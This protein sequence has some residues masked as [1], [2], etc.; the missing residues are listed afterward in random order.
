[1][2][3][4]AGLTLAL[5]ADVGVVNA[6]PQGF[7]FGIPFE[8]PQLPSI[9]CTTPSAQSQAI[10]TT[11]SWSAVDAPCT[12]TV[13]VRST[14]TIKPLPVTK[15]KM[16]TRYGS[17]TTTRPPNVGAAPPVVSS[18]TT[19]VR[20]VTNKSL[21]TST[22]GTV[23]SFTTTTVVIKA[24]ST[25]IVPVPPGFR[26][27]KR[28]IIDGVTLS[29]KDETDGDDEDDGTGIQPA[30]QTGI[31]TALTP[32]NLI[33]VTTSSTTVDGPETVSDTEMTSIAL[34]VNYTFPTPRILATVTAVSDTETDTGIDFET[35]T[36]TDM[37]LTGLTYTLPTP[38]LISI[39]GGDS[40]ETGIETVLPTTTFDT[41]YTSQITATPVLG[42]G[43]G[44]EDPVTES[45]TDTTTMEL[46]GVFTFPSPQILDTPTTATVKCNV[47]FFKNPCKKVTKKAMRTKTLRAKTST[48]TTTI[49]VPKVTKRALVTVTSTSTEVYTVYTST[50]TSYAACN[51]DNLISKV[52]NQYIQRF[53]DRTNSFTTP[54]A[55]AT[56]CCIQAVTRNNINLF[57]YYNG[58]CELYPNDG[59]CRAPVGFIFASPKQDKASGIVAGN[60]Y[61]GGILHAVSS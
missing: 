16:I 32:V 34:G 58:V 23:I 57:G 53:G 59:Q 45:D 12:R 43:I 20:T 50:T 26:S 25:S 52:N 40:S 6:I 60:G 24:V 33:R 4:L 18:S 1:M 44:T 37:N 17:V 9:R 61:C 47:I 42:A 28:T 10:A 51:T 13:T 5:A 38:V 8:W 27:A 49:T 39:T 19:T 35:Q 15:T 7:G 54:A 46:G 36:Q 56:D 14:T 29:K 2:R 31:M 30:N 48:V 55:N 22:P 21:L 11:T 41:T 3:S